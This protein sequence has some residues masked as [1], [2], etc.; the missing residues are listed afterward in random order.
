MGVV[1]AGITMAAA[2]G[3][4]M[5]HNQSRFGEDVELNRQWAYLLLRRINFTKQKAT[6][7]KSKHSTAD[8][9]WQKQQFLV[10]VV[11]T[12]EMVEIPAE[13]ILNWDQTGIKTV[14][15]STWMIDA[16]GSKRLEVAG[17]NDKHSSQ[18]CCVWRFSS[19]QGD[20]PR[21]N[22]LLSSP[23]PVSS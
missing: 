6:T 3:N 8:F 23:L 22:K 13:F 18:P 7:A 16:Q 17:I 10:D 1:S 9:A 14:P 2:G 5:S 21:E 20:L 11:T 4:L 19:S 12:T 15:S